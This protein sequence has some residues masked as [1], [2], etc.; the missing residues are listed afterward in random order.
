MQEM[1]DTSGLC[2]Y[3]GAPEV[4]YTAEA[5]REDDSCNGLD[6]LRGLFP[7]CAPSAAEYPISLSMSLLVPTFLGRR[8][9]HTA[10]SDSLAQCLVLSAL[11]RAVAEVWG[12][13]EV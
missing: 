4:K 6:A 13:L 9:T 2:L 11:A 8:H 10:M 7:Q 12:E 5:G 1:T 3:Y